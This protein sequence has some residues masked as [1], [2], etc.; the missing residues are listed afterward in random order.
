MAVLPAK[1]VTA[2]G[3]GFNDWA[4]TSGV[5][6]TRQFV[7]Y[8]NRNQTE[9]DHWPLFASGVTLER[10]RPAYLVMGHRNR[11]GIWNYLLLA[12]H[13]NAKENR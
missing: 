3:S 11:E 6:L 1:W 10:R 9:S 5:D 2:I 7:K 12:A 8:W 13:E 4:I